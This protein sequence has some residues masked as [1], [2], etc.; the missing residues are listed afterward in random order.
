MEA[1]ETGEEEVLKGGII[2]DFSKDGMIDPHVHGG[3]PGLRIHRRVP[4]GP[5][6]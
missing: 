1:I 6:G 5:F 4:D 2:V 3:D